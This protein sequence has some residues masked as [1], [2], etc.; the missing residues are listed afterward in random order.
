MG[1]TEDHGTPGMEGHH[2]FWC[3]YLPGNWQLRYYAGLSLTNFLLFLAEPYM[4]LFYLFW[5]YF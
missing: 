4:Y 5:V 2:L 3:F 1:P